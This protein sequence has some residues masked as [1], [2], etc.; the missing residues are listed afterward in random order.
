MIIKNI[1]LQRTI[2][3]NYNN[4]FGELE[5]QTENQGIFKFSTVENYEK[6]IKAG[7]YNISYTR[8]NKFKKETLE[9]TD[10]K[11]RYGIRIH[12][13]NRGTDLQGCIAVGLYNHKKEIPSQIYYSRASVEQLEAMLWRYKQI[14]HIKDIKDDKENISK[15]SREY[16]TETA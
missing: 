13:G 6:R 1:K 12:P 8:S 7:Y 4:L 9:L 14:I 5:I 16:I 15:N 3:G 10:V 11:Q 2:H